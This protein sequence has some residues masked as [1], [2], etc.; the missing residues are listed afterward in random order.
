V[1]DET[2]RQ[3]LA[4]FYRLPDIVAGGDA[5]ARLAFAGRGLHVVPVDGAG[6]PGGKA[7]DCCADG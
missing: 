7:G 3:F 1:D 6:L 4:G 5:A 2:A